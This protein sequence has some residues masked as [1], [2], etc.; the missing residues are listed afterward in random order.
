MD[1]L[2]P[3]LINLHSV[4]NITN[5]VPLRASA[6]GWVKEALKTVGWEEGDLI[7]AG[8]PEYF[9]A[10][11]KVLGLPSTPASVHQAMAEEAVQLTLKS[12]LRKIK[13]KVNAE[14]TALS[15]LGEQFR[16]QAD[17]SEVSRQIKQKALAAEM[18][19]IQKEEAVLDEEDDLED[20]LE[21]GSE[22]APPPQPAGLCPC[23]G[24]NQAKPYESPELDI[25]DQRGYLIYVLGGP[26]FTKEYKL[27]NGRCTVT[28]QTLDSQTEELFTEQY[29]KDYSS[30][31]IN[32][33]LIAQRRYAI[34]HTA[35]AIKRFYYDPKLQLTPPPVPS[36]WSDSFTP[37]DGKTRLARYMSEWFYKSVVSIELQNELLTKW[38]EF[39]QLVNRLQ[40][41]L[42]HQDFWGGPISV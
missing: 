5:P 40:Q 21:D 8:L 22:A 30:G 42:Y 20:D 24:W 7:P 36:I 27:W 1:A 41:E 11:F 16:E 32:I 12:A 34:Y 6:A 13:D 17:D 38:R 4:L 15:N 9:G 23:C 25:T 14:E 29:S 31:V 26:A 3:D 10:V 18:E 35:L 33:P 28:F 2:N 39:N 19:R 37:E